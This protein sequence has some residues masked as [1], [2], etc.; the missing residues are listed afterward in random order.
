MAKLT[1]PEPNSTGLTS[2]GR[3][4][5]TPSAMAP[6]QIRGETIDGRADIYSLGILAFFMLTGRNP[7][8]SADTTELEQM[9]LGQPPPRPSQLA[10]VSA[11]LDAVILKCLE[12]TRENRYANA[13]LFSEAFR[14]A[15]GLAP[16]SAASA[17]TVRALAIYFE[18]WARDPDSDPDIIMD[19]VADVLDAAERLI[20]DSG[21]EIALHTSSAVLGARAIIEG[22]SIDLDMP[23]AIGL[24]ARLHHEALASVPGDLLEA[25]SC[26]HV[27]QALVR[28]GS[29]TLEG[30]PMM[31][32]AAWIPN[33]RIPGVCA[34]TS[35]VEA[36]PAVFNAIP[37][38]HVR[39]L[40]G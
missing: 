13:K 21:L 28:E 17:R 5:G 1:D 40:R 19:A 34:T 15:A 26:V 8:V 31:R 23:A 37:P 10:P 38:N 39:V 7:F 24:A 18:L 36:A 27:G 30:G 25:V 32:L 4:I 16:K 11:S 2:V 33:D 29:T 14:E 3:R 6:E 22:D 9:H 20:R 12:K 35:A